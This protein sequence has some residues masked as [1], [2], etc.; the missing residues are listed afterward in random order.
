MIE[1]TKKS[2]NIADLFYLIK[3]FRAKKEDEKKFYKEVSSKLIPPFLSS[4]A[5]LND[6]LRVAKLF[7]IG[8]ATVCISLVGLQ[9]WRFKGALE[10]ALN[11][12]FLIV[13]GVVDFMRVR[14]GMIPENVV[15]FFA[16]FMADQ[17]GTFTYSNVG[18]RYKRAA[19]FMS[20]A[21]RESFL[22]ELRKKEKDYRELAVTE[23]FSP[24]PVSKF[25]QLKDEAGNPYYLVHL[26]G[27]LVRF[28]NDQK[29]ATEEEILTLKFKTT[30]IVP[31]KPWFFELT[32]LTRQTSEEF[33]RLEVARDRFAKAGGEKNL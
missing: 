6:R 17:V 9:E 22:M 11:K 7:S 32:S 33:A 3:Y 30:R 26:R 8:V 1:K 14:P 27:N 25:E 4:N 13:P 10:H 2:K 28:S 21:L 23:I 19:E 15:F 31:D 29:I 16:E 5:V 18:E 20:P 12:E 24:F